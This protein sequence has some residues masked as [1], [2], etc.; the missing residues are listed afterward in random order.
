M[1]T[2]PGYATWT[3]SSPQNSHFL[4]WWNSSLCRVTAREI[5]TQS[6]Q[7]HSW[8]LRVLPISILQ[9]WFS[10]SSKECTI[11]FGEGV[12]RY[13][14]IGIRLAGFLTLRPGGEWGVHGVQPSVQH[15]FPRTYL[16]VQSRAPSWSRA[17]VENGSSETWT[18]RAC[19]RI[20]KIIPSIWLWGEANMHLLLAW[21]TS[22]ADKATF[23]SWK[24]MPLSGAWSF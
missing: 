4:A 20:I 8:H 23:P 19:R 18:V 5:L 15:H 3:V 9:D 13:T 2:S 11:G 12:R 16:L 6:Q 17:Q 21:V 14:T 1:K 10:R 7:W 24:R 22:A